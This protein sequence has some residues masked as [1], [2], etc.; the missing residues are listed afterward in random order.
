MTDKRR[1][2]RNNGV[3]VPA[4]VLEGWAVQHYEGREQPYTLY[5]ALVSKRRGPP[6]GPNQRQR[7][8]QFEV[9]RFCWTVAEAETTSRI[10]LGR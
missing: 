2:G 5:R 7:P 9:V 6:P 3:P 8:Q 1:H 4:L 10:P